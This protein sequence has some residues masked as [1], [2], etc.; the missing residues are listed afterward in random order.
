MGVFTS[1]SVHLRCEEK[2]TLVMSRDGGVQQMEVHGLLVMRIADARYA[3]S[4]MHMS[5]ND[6]RQAQIQVRACGVCD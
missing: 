4:Q 1:C 5:N 2:L 3:S 6:T